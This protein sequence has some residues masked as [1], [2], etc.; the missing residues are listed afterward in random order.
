MCSLCL[1]HLL[2]L[3]VSC[4]LA[5][6]VAATSLL[7][8]NSSI[9]FLF[10]FAGILDNQMTQQLIPILIVNREFN[11]VTL[12]TRKQTWRVNR[13]VHLLPTPFRIYPLATSMLK[14]HS[15]LS[16]MQHRALQLAGQVSPKQTSHFKTGLHSSWHFKCSYILQIPLNSAM[17]PAL[18]HACLPPATINCTSH[19]TGYHTLRVS[20]KLLFHPV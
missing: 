12:H 2:L 19:Q 14:A 17:K 10:S 1:L 7:Q 20:L 6:M 4:R 9:E 8:Q 5:A 11:L 18:F 3:S 16:L 13:T 15:P